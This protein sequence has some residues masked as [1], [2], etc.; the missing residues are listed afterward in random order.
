MISSNGILRDDH[1][2]S[3]VGCVSHFD[4]QGINKKKALKK[5]VLK[6][7]LDQRSQFDTNSSTKINIEYIFKLYDDFFDMLLSNKT[8][9]LLA[10][11]D[12]KMACFRKP[13]DEQIVNDPPLSSKFASPSYFNQSATFNF[14]S[15]RIT[16]ETATWFASREIGLVGDLFM[17]SFLLE[18]GEELVVIY[19]YVLQ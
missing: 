16:P 6:T 3:Y 17:E 4:Y 14:H 13:G 11:T 7:L 8:D 2:H 1:E 10:K 5:Y 18:D 19:G 9:A 15:V 12:I